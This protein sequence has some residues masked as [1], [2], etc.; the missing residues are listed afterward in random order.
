MKNNTDQSL[1]PCLYFDKNNLFVTT[2]FAFKVKSII[3]LQM[4]A[5]TSS[6]KT[7]NRQY[8]KERKAEMQYIEK[9]II[10]S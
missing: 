5:H 8:I 1:N 6:V 9:F 3:R 7:V 10:N 2:L 4:N